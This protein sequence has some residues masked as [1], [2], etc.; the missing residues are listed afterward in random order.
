MEKLIAKFYKMQEPKI[1]LKK[2]KV[3]NLK[4][5]DLDL[6]HNELIVFTGVSGSGKSSLAFD[7]IYIEGQR[8]YVESLST[9]ARRHLGDLTKPDAELISGISPTIAIEQK[10]AGRNPRSTV[11]TITG[12][13]D[14]M[15]VL[16]ARIGIAHC[17]VSGEVVTP[18]SAEQILRTIRE[19]PQ[20][21]RLI[22][23]APFAKNKKAEFKEDFAELVRKGYTRVRLDGKIIDLSEEVKIDGKVAHDVD[24][25]I[26]RLGVTPEEDN[27]LA[28]AVSQALEAGQGLMS[29]LQADSGK[30]TLFSQHAFSPKSGL[31]Y[32]P[33]EPSDFS[34]NHPNGMCPTCQGLGMIQEFDL[35]KI[36]N[37]DLSIAEDCCSIS[38]SYKTV[39]YG[40]IYDNLSRLYGFDVHTPW[41]NLPEKGKKVLLY[42]TEKKWTEMRFV[43]PHKRSRWTE[44]VQWRG[45]LHE[46]KE[47]FNQAQSDLYRAK[48]KEL[49]HESICSDCQGQKIRPYPA[50]A[51][52][53]KKKIAEITGMAVDDA[54]QF[55][56]NL[57]LG[58]QERTIGEEL[59]KEVVQ[60]LEFLNGV[61]LH[62]LSL[63][64]T[65]PTLSGGES[66]RVR[67]AS[68][69][70]SGLV[71]ATYVLDE[72]SIGLHPRDNHK[73][74]QTL[75]S[76]RDKGNTVIVV[77]HDEETIRSADTI[78]DVGP[79]AGQ[80]GGKIIVKG[81][82]HALLSSPESLTGAYLSGKKQIPVPKRRSFTNALKIE[83]ASHHNLKQIDVEI[84]LKV[85]VAV[86]GVSGSGKS[87]L[88]TDTLYPLL[89]NHLH[90]AQLPVG[91]HKALRGIDQIDKVIAIDQTP[92]GRTPRSNPATFIKLFDEI[93]DL[94]SN[95]PQSVAQ[96]YKA[97]RFSF[98]VKD[99]SCP[100]CSGMGMIKID[101]DFMEDEWVPC[102]HCKGQRFDSNTLS[103]LYRGKNIFEVLEL[104][105]AEGAE[106]F[107]AIPSLKTKLDTLLD[108]GLDYIKLGQP[109]PTLSGGEAQRIKL[110]KELSRP[111]SGNTLYILDEPTTGLHF[112]DIKKLI[113]VLQKLV[114]R[115][116]TVLVIEH[117]MDL[118]K[119]ADW[120]IDLG[121]E[122]GKGGGEIVAVGTPEKIGK[123]KTSTGEA[124]KPFLKPPGIEAPP[125]APPAMR[126]PLQH[127]LVEGAQQNNLKGIDVQIPRGKITLC[128]GPSGSGKSSFAF[129]TVYAEGQRRYI[130]SMSAY[131]RQFVKQMPKPKVEQIEGLS[132][133]IAIEQKSHAG[134]PRSTIGTMTESYDFLRI[135]YAHMGTPFCP[136]TGEEIRTI[137]KEFVLN[138]LME[139]PEG[140]K[141]HLLS[142]LV[143]KRS[144]KFEEMKD[145]L[146][147]QGYLRIRLNN[148]Y[149]ELDQE[150]PFDKQRK[151]QLFLVIDRLLLSKENEKRIFDGI[152]QAA[153]LSGGTLVAAL[154][155]RDLFFN[156]AFAVPT[157][158]K[159][160]PPITP[161][162]FSFNTEQGMCLDCQGL[163]FQYG[164]DLTRHAPIMKMH[165]VGLLRLLWKENLTQDTLSV[166]LA[167]LKQNKIE[168]RTLFAE[169]TP[170]QLQ[171]LFSGGGEIKTDGLYFKWRGFN[172]VLALLAKSSDPEIREPLLPLLDQH[173]CLSCQGTRINPLAR[174]VK[175]HNR[176]IA[177]FCR[178]SIDDAAEFLE[179]IADHDFL[180]ETLKQLKSRLHFLR[181]IGL[182]YL[183]LERS[184]PTLSGGEAQRIRLARQ[185]GSGLT[186][187]LY[188]LDEPTI[189]LHPYDNERLN[190]ALLQLCSLGNTL[191]LVEHDPL[192]I[193]LADYILDFGPH[194]GKQGG[195]IMAKGTFEEI[196][197]NPLSLTGQYL[198]GKKKIPLPSSRR[199]PKK[200]LKLRNASLH[201]LK[202]I[203][204]DFPVQTMICITGVSGSGKSTLLTDL[205]QPPAEAALR[206]KRGRGKGSKEVLYQGATLEGMDAFDK[207]LVL[208]QNP[209]GHTLRADVSTYVDLLAPLRYFFASLPE[210]KARGL[211]PK[212]FSFN[213]RKGMCTTCWGL[214]TRNISLQFLPPVKVVCE[215]C[216]GYRLNPLS[217]KVATKGKHLGAILQMSVEEALS[218]LP[219]IPKCVRILETLISVGLGYLQLGQEIAT[220]SGGEAQRIRLS[221]E[222]AKRSSGSTLY[223]FDEPTVGLHTDDIVKLLH[224]FNT[225]VD[226]GN[227]VIIIEH[228]LDVIAAADHLIDMGP[229]SGRK[230]GQIVAAGTPEQVARDKKSLTAPYLREHLKFLKS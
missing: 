172:A 101:M 42:G 62:Y 156:L 54:L 105:V 153:T 67:L 201:N 30:E 31:S 63:E 126:H 150:I 129:E 211:A 38:S 185:L 41:K 49:M 100:H 125:K 161:H 50:A 217:L 197:A 106:F 149:Y 93:R 207:L 34:F 79:L 222:L 9:Y 83:K 60:R 40:N 138:R 144:E 131:A 169:L 143:M 110:A 226:L 18:Q 152:D 89:S 191:L 68:Q 210:A 80:F 159:S 229:G 154:E 183:S 2:V 35:Q 155:E 200:L 59:L 3:H 128:T 102:E 99:G 15:R 178:L 115:G 121:P 175:I 33:L 151:N 147:R 196:K 195:K 4:S 22:L 189:G 204:I 113:D 29:I 134:N 14:F 162:T 177:D 53:G 32:G 86:T 10:T 187:C 11:G 85:L 141:L 65:A 58:K 135:L 168:P 104:T 139:L 205:L 223:L 208:D 124:L 166:F 160:Y 98:N 219:P 66:Q 199:E 111:S 170:A 36:I 107:S 145:K 203:G 39:R 7:T 77:E 61:G 163:G 44:Y 87:S 112:H 55:F 202:N 43:H 21:T 69:I 90:H 221:R 120:I 127:I 92:I 224:I 228:N 140:T 176:S 96:G 190:R 70:G 130:E 24:I 184:A 64:R 47:R 209:I 117:N 179:K 133:A 72:P 1:V 157:T 114:E 194:A 193:Q 206:G 116:N 109:S 192:T 137:S 122:G 19:L 220:L 188:V 181:A 95:L 148:V 225:L 37:P 173:V 186:G 198:S 119:T 84:P 82:L 132:P 158:G 174:N 6:N 26:D 73:L 91:K 13:Y 212:N 214:G 97:G 71:G 118:V 57:K 56:Q 165:S 45:I 103:I 51:T 12:I 48:M 20:G 75:K 180:E 52:V 17:P 136:E 76:L 167:L 23:L 215:S 28:E 182:G 27:R 108:V 146:Q 216:H 88:I 218:F 123:L 25:V 142:P 74:L 78:V 81:D 16:F 46:G 227:T 8:R 164:A 94:F 5:V 213:H 230:G 171:L